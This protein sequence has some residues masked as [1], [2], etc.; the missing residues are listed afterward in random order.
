MASAVVMGC[1][2]ETDSAE[3]LR[4]AAGRGDAEAQF[5]LGWM[6]ASGFGDFEEDH[7]E[8]LGWYRRAA[9]QGLARAQSY[10]GTWYAHGTA[11]EQDFIQAATWC[12]RGAEQGNAD[13]QLCL[14]ML[15]AGGCG[16]EPDGTESARWYRL[17][18]RSGEGKSQARLG[19]MYASGEG[20]VAQD[21]VE[22]D[23]WYRRAVEP[24]TYRPTRVAGEELFSGRFILF[25]LY[26]LA[27]MYQDGT[28]VPRN[29]IAAYKWLDIANR[30]RADDSGT[31]TRGT[32]RRELDD[33][34]QKMTSEQVAAARHAAD[35]FIETYRIGSYEVWR[36][37]AVTASMEAREQQVF[38]T[39][40]WYPAI[41]VW[42]PVVRWWWWATAAIR[43]TFSPPIIPDALT[44]TGSSGTPGC[45][46]GATTSA[47]DGNEQG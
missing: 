41:R 16:V 34:A 19:D 44:A 29:E 32:A 22:A 35:A 30:W 5:Q 39:F 15:Y 45:M 21:P 12:R 24:G 42:Y 25:H 17:A 46:A 9:E 6:Y 10:L 13:G 14:A 28:G 23:T 1:A 37:M 3:E 36:N 33:L 31:T 40:R 4:D 38:A 8:A 43:A 2:H 20:G 11:L 26:V 7:A 47:S 18:A 27:R